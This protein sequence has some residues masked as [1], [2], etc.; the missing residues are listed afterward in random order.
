MLLNLQDA[1][2]VKSQGTLFDLSDKNPADRE[3]DEQLMESVDKINRLFGK[4]TVFFSSQGID[5]KNQKWRGAS[6]HCS[7]NY[8]LNFADLPVVKAR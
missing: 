8:T 2:A 3:R 1:N 6:E 4:G 5:Q 7:P